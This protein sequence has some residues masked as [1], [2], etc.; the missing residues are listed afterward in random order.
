MYELLIA[1]NNINKLGEIKAILGD[2]PVKLLTPSDLDIT[3]DVPEDGNSYYENA[4]KKAQAFFTL[5]G[6]VT[7]A[8][9][10]GLEVEVLGGLPGLRSHRFSPIFDATDKDRRDYLLH[11]LEKFPRPWSATFH[12][13]IVIVDTAGCSSH[14]HGTCC[15]EIIPEERGANGFGYDPIFFMPD[16]NATMAELSDQIKNVASHRA[17]ALRNAVPILS[18]IF[19]FQVR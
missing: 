4:L 17:N 6:M 12:C 11:R 8:D 9:D 7:L 3:I 19:N 16:L 2:I 1:S 18:E 15:G 14:V 5:S 10:S 13:E